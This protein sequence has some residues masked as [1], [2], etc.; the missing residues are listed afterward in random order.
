[1]DTERAIPTE[2]DLLDTIQQEAGC[3][4]LSDL[5]EPQW[6]EAVLRAIANIAEARYP[7]HVWRR[8]G[9][10][11]MRKDCAG[12]TVSDICEQIKAHLMQFVASR[13]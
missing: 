1:M 5:H 6:A 13:K 7:A 10:Y 9:G 12:E 8:V 2:S 4:Y 11:I 3:P